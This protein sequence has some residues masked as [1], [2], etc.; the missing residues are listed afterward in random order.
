VEILVDESIFLMFG[1]GKPFPYLFF[2]Q[3]TPAC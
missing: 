3:Y 2:K 1:V